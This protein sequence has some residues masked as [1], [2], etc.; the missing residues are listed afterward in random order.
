[1]IY[2]LKEVDVAHKKKIYIIRRWKFLVLFWWNII[3]SFV[4][5]LS[6]VHLIQLSP[7]RGLLIV[8]LETVQK[9]YNPLRG[10]SPKDHIRLK[11]GRGGTQKDNIGLFTQKQFKN[12]YGI[13]KHFIMCGVLKT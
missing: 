4:L 7:E 3:F 10:R 13:Y 1:M 6:I 12:Q 11:G 9:L 8:V 2:K 5:L